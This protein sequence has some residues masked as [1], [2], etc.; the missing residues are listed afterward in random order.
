MEFAESKR[1]EGRVA[2]VEA[3]TAHQHRRPAQSPSW[4]HLIAAAEATVLPA[5]VTRGSDDGRVQRS[6]LAPLPTPSTAN[7]ITPRVVQRD[8]NVGLIRR[9]RTKPGALKKSGKKASKKFPIGKT[10][11]T[12]T[13]NGK[14]KVTTVSGMPGQTRYS[15]HDSAPNK[16]A[17]IH[18]LQHRQTFRDLSHPESTA[19]STN[20][21]FNV[22]DRS[23]TPET[24][25]KNSD[26]RMPQGTAICHKIS[27][28]EIRERINTYLTA[29][30]YG[31]LDTYL[32]D[33]VH[34]IKPDN[35]DETPTN[36]AY[37][38]ECQK[39]LATAKT[40]LA[41]LATAVSP[42]EKATA[43]HEVGKCIANSPVNL[44]VGDS[45]TNSTIQSAF[46]QN[47]YGDEART[48]GFTA[49]LTP[50]TRRAKPLS[51]KAP[52]KRGKAE[53]KSSQPA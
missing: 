4:A 32:R 43:A 33:L 46:D 2:Q 18:V 52:V 39:K 22:S 37:W 35:S 21:T 51:T 7:L 24:G 11:G 53:M 9:A 49:P 14:Q 13:K 41:V 10:S 6:P 44:F 19:H 48:T 26:A 42:L 23:T 3:A 36:G 25:Q 50:R 34:Y 31:A 16:R 12:T 15:G 17:L 45:T 20:K 30:S 38:D 8:P 29:A 40:Q 47:T 27:D 28:N 1:H 5:S